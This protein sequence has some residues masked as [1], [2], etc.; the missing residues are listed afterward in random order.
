MTQ[1]RDP[2][3]SKKKEVP[4]QTNGC[5]NKLAVSS[6]G[7]EHFFPS[8]STFE[9]RQIFSSQVRAFPNLPENGSSELSEFMIKKFRVFSEFSK[10]GFWGF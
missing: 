9:Y 8:S 1:E 4:W 7:V 10:M 3:I 2:E 5:V 6:D